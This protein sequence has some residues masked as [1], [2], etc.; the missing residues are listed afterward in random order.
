MRIVGVN[1]FDAE[2]DAA[3]G[4]LR[5]TGGSAPFL[6]CATDDDQPLPILTEQPTVDPTEWPINM[7][8]VGTTYDLWGNDIKATDCGNPSSSF[9]GEVSEGEYDLPGRGEV[10][11]G[12][13]NGP[14]L[15][16][17]QELCSSADIDCGPVRDPGPAL[18][19]LERPERLRLRHVLLADGRLPASPTSPTTTS[20]ACSS[21][22]SNVPDAS[23]LGHA[24]AG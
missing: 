12:N 20:T 8:A 3:A 2:A 6:I 4:L 18:L 24:G 23:G 14:V 19:R 17:M 13:S 1:E 9:R 11:T 5:V 21:A 22:P 16:K 15:A 7:A 10:D